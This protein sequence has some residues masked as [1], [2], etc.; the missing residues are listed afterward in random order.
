MTVLL[1]SLA[2][3]A[4]SWSKALKESDLSMPLRVWPDVGDPAE[5]DYA[6]VA[7]P[8]KGLLADLPNLKAILSL[9]AGVDHI[10]SDPTH[11]RDVPIYRMIE[12]GLTGGMVEFVLSQV[13]NLHLGNYEVIAAQPRR[14]WLR[15]PRG[16]YGLEPMMHER[17]VGVLGLG[18]MGR[19][20]AEALAGIGFQVHGWSRSPKSFNGIN[21][22]AGAEGLDTML[23]R[24]EILVNLLP[25]TPETDGL[26]NEK[27][28]D[29]M[30]RGAAL[31]NVGRG[32][33]VVDADL[34]SALDDGRLSRAVLDVFH[35]EPLPDDHPFW[36]HPKVTIYPHIASVTRVRSGVPVLIQSLE[37]LDA[38]GTPPALF[39]PKRG[40]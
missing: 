3:S 2:D 28:F 26:L 18:E 40:Y 17:V 16:P 19:N 29:R 33:H 30:P 4:E 5:I 6:I 13:L 25:L 38:G 39:D 21:C 9:W 20:C 23:R 12:P 32:Q 10:T 11:P 7:K 27:V 37:T 31:L 15:A 22:H 8:P 35:I 36:T 14:E 1:A 34:V 24:A